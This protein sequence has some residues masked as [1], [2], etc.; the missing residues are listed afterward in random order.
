MA[1]TF[2]KKH[3]NYLVSYFWFPF[4]VF[5]LFYVIIVIFLSLL[6]F[7][8]E[9]YVFPLLRKHFTYKTYQCKST[10]LYLK[11]AGLASRK[12][13]HLQKKFTYVVSVFASVF[14]CQKS[15]SRDLDFPL[16]PLTGKFLNFV[17]TFL[18][19]D[20]QNKFL[21]GPV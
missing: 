19:A 18:D 12:I 8:V 7:W 9:P 17:G 5:F 21:S 10:S 14:L 2:V 15:R 20:D 13:V 3:T 1:S 6:S 4:I 16:N 11:K